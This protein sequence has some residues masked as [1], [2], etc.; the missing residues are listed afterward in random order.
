MPRHRRSLCALVALACLLAPAL[1][2]C[3]GGDGASASAE[4]PG[5]VIARVAG[6]LKG[7]VSEAELKEVVDR[8]TTSEERQELREELEER[9]QPEQEEEQSESAQDQEASEQ[10]QE[11]ESEPAQES[12]QEQ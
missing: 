3:A 5:G 4:A 1:S 6:V 2:A 11:A 12:E 10:E 8:E 7:E 9:E